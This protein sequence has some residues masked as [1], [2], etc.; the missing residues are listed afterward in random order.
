MK[1]EPDRYS[2][3]TLEEFDTMDEA[4]EEG[5]EWDAEDLQINFNTID[6]LMA[7][8]VLTRILNEEIGLACDEMKQPYY[9]RKE[10]VVL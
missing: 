4:E 1:H 8:D 10:A 5:Y 3:L 9:I 2:E 7:V 6:Y